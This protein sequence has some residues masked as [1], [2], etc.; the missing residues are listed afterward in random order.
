[1]SSASESDLRDRDQVV[2][3]EPADLALDAALLVGALDAGLAVERVEPVVRPE[4]DPPVG[5]D[6]GPAEQHPRHR[7]LQVVVADLAG[8][9]PAQHVE[10]VHVAFQE[11][12]LALGCANARCTALPEYDSRSVN[13]KHFV[14]HPGQ[15][16]PQLAEV[17]LGLRARRVVSAARTPRQR[18]ARLARISGRRLAT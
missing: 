6:P 10:R 14:Q 13:R 16:D 8:R 11:R 2:A 1:M 4:R 3:A 18:P 7:R 5:L 9:D 15:A 12:L 17:D